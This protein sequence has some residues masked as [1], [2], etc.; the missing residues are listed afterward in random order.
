MY[1]PFAEIVEKDTDESDIIRA[2]LA[3]DAASLEKLVLRHQAWIYNIAFRMVMSADDACDA[4]QEVLIKMVTRLSAYDP[5]KASFRTWLYRIAVN[6]VLSM[7][8]TAF[9]VRFADMDAYFSMIDLLPDER[10][11]SRPDAKVLAEET[12]ISCMS[13]M[14]LCFSR[15]ERLV[16]ILGVVFGVSDA[17]GS[18]VM[19][20]SRANFRKILSRARGKLYSYMNERCGLLN[21]DGICRCELI[22]RALAERGHIDASNPRYFVNGAKTVKDVLLE[23]WTISRDRTCAVLRAFPGEPVL[24]SARHDELAARNAER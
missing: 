4:T 16:F 18:D 7:K 15:R 19:D 2:A 1:N 17:V 11:Y 12:R 21:G 14:L 3:G 23:R 6:H 5:A 9:E 22:S 24:R 8:K 10:P 13:G 20:I